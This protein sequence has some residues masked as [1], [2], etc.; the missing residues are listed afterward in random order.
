MNPSVNEPG[1]YVNATN[2][3]SMGRDNWEKYMNRCMKTKIANGKSKAEAYSACNLEY[4]D[5]KNNKR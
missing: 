1:K 4:H 2:H 3:H 5:K